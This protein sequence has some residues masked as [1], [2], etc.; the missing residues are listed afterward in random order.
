M[1][2][3][4]DEDAMRKQL[5]SDGKTTDMLDAR[6]ES[7]ELTNTADH[8]TSVQLTVIPQNQLRELNTMFDLQ[9]ARNDSLFG[10][11][12]KSNGNSTVTLNNSGVIVA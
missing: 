1:A 3:T 5:K 10:W 8:G 2:N 7:G 12:H 4:G 6:I 11:M 9:P